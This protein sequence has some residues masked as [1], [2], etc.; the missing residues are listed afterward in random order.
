MRVR[1]PSVLLADRRRRRAALG[2]LG[3]CLQASVFALFL[4]AALANPR[5]ARLAAQSPSPVEYERYDVDVQL[6]DDGDLSVRIRQRVRFAGEFER[7]FLEV[8]KDFTNDIEDIAVYLANGDTL[9][10]MSAELTDSPESVSVAWSYPRTNP[11]DVLDFVIDYTAAG[12]LWVYNDRDILRW[13]AI[14]ADR[15]GA[16][17]QSSRITVRLPSYIPLDAVQTAAL[18]ASHVVDRLDGA[19]VFTL[20]DDLP[21][22]QFFNIEVSFPHGLVNAAIQEWQKAVDSEDLEAKLERLDVRIWIKKNGTLVIR[23]E[24]DVAVTAGVLYDAYR[25]IKRLYLDDVTHLRV[26]HDDRPL[27]PG[28]PPCDECLVVS[29]VPRQD[30]W[31]RYDAGRNQ[32]RIDETRTGHV[33]ADWFIRPAYPAQTARFAVEFAVRGAVRQQENAQSFQWQVVPDFGIWPAASSLH[34]CPPEGLTADQLDVTHSLPSVSLRTDAGGC[35]SGH[36]PEPLPSGELWEI[37]V[38]MPSNAVTN[39]VPQWQADLENALAEQSAAAITRARRQ[40]AL[41]VVAI[42][43][44][45]AFIAGAVVGWF[46]WGRRRLREQLGGYVSEP[47][48]ALA[49]GIVAY[50][51]DGAVRSNSLLASL[52]QLAM[53]GLIELDMSDELA[54]RLRQTSEVSEADLRSP[55]VGHKAVRNTHLTYL[56]NRVILPAASAEKYTPLGDLSA[57][58]QRALPEFYSAMAYDA[59]VYLLGRRFSRKRALSNPLV[60]MLAWF[61]AAGI[62]IYSTF[63][64]SLPSSVSIFLV[65]ATFLVFFTLHAVRELGA[66][67]AY[68]DLGAAERAKWIRFKNYLADLKKYGDLSAARQVMERHFAYAVALGVEENV[69]AQIDRRMSERPTWLAPPSSPPRPSQGHA[70]AQASVVQTGP[71]PPQQR[72]SANKRPPIVRRVRPATRLAG[73]SRTLGASLERTSA[74]LGALLSTAA[75][76]TTGSPIRILLNSAGGTRSMSWE[77]NEP[78]NSI[79]DDILNQSMSD[80]RRAAAERERSSLP[81]R[82]RSATRANSPSRSSGGFGSRRTTFGSTG[83]SSASSNSRASGGFKSSSGSRRSGGGGRSGF[84]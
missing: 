11:G 35:L 61:A 15:S 17:V 78:V 76:S 75:G 50:L 18:G 33:R 77:G 54:L 8:P 68:T 21:D 72:P 79:L 13:D 43:T 45:V 52:L 7:A 23:E 71:P 37:D 69:L 3:L 67:G 47:P 39:T 19:F 74:S 27:P 46:R 14:H 30:D 83:G 2:R 53:L 22:G 55:V 62:I 59:Q 49:P 48:S 42:L 38:T 82:S 56:F 60:L 64:F 63:R 25:E 44:A 5:A 10:P 9:S 41:L 29:G 65:G 84:S 58:L 32:V 26:L 40:L 20:Q 12:A 36:S 70:G 24:M 66:G 1:I 51:A 6:E 34:I 31:V 28:D 57:K 81:A 4:V 80:M 16:P 73:I